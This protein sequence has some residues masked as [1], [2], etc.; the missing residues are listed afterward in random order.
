VACAAFRSLDIAELA[1][2]SRMWQFG[3]RAETAS[4]SSDSSIA[5]VA[6]CVD[7]GIEAPVW[8]TFVKQ[9]L[10][11][12]HAGSPYVARYVARS[13]SAFGLR[14]GS[15]IAIVSPTPPVCDR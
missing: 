14:K 7:A 11:V 4:R 3:H 8:L 6:S 9:P 2:T 13:D 10:L 5:Q 1:S 12:V 15:M